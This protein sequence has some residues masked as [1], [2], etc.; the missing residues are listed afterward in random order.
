MPKKCLLAFVALALAAPVSA[1]KNW[2]KAAEY[3][4]YE[5]ATHE[6]EP[7]VQVEILLE[8]ET[9]NPNSEYQAERLALLINAYKNAGRPVDAFA[10]HT[11]FQ[12]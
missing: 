1:Q 3:E 8:W 6:T 5:R 2:A 11:T 4:L 12:T 9:A 7:A 10:R